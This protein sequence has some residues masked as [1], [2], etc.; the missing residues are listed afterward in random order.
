MYF[1]DLS[2]YIYFTSDYKPLPNVYNVG[3]LAKLRRFPK[4]APD[5]AFV[6]QLKRLFQHDQTRVNQTRGIHAC[7]WCNVN[8]QLGEDYLGTA[9]IWV[10]GHDGVIYAAPTLIIHYV[11]EHH[12]RPPADFVAAVM[13]FDL[14]A[15]WDGNAIYTKLAQETDQS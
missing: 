10:P 12:Y 8:I 13:A 4:A 1:K 6:E 7:P 11:A 15:E 14:G 5:P 2:P 3:W 9:E